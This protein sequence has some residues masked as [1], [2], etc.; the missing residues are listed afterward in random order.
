MFNELGF[1]KFDINS[2]IIDPNGD[3]INPRIALISKSGGGKSFLIRDILYHMRD[4]PCGTVIAPTCKMNKFYD[5]FLGGSYI[6]YE[7]KEEIIPKVMER[8]TKMLAKNER[9]IKQNKKPIDPRCFLVMDDC[10]S[11]KD[12]WLR[13]PCILSIF[14]E[15]RHYQITYLLSM[16]YC[17]GIPPEL[18]SNFDYIF[19]LAEDIVENRK[20]LY[21]DYAGIF[22]DKNL[23]EKSFSAITNNYGCMVINNRIKNSNNLKDRVFWYK[24]EFK[25]NFQL[26][27]ERFIK[28]NKDNY[29]PEYE[30]K[31]FF[32]LTNYNKKTHVNIKLIK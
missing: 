8:Q 9:R 29:D 27:S 5:P 2:M 10:M 20:K 14:N 18:R 15:G 31:N 6:H 26:G 7:Y 30:K 23:F 24:A 11:S 28:F 12:K 13:D 19:M 22:P 17:K 32:D 4:I 21:Q 3:Y 16:Q 25:D 1:S